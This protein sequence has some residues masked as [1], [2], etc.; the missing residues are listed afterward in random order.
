MIIFRPDSGVSAIKELANR[1]ITHLEDTRLSEL[2]KDESSLF[3]QSIQ[4]MVDAGAVNEAITVTVALSCIITDDRVFEA[5]TSNIDYNTT[6]IN[7][8]LDYIFSVASYLNVNAPSTVNMYKIARY[9]PPSDQRGPVL[10]K[11]IEDMNNYN[12]ELQ[13][14]EDIYFTDSLITEGNKQCKKCKQ[15]RTMRYNQQ[16]RSCDES[17]TNVIICV[18]CRNVWTE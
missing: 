11:I 18:T 6:S 13:I 16:L 8:A 9:L 15:K 5:F 12:R 14:D 10:T 3:M 2:V 1:V 17:S 4:Y 7:D